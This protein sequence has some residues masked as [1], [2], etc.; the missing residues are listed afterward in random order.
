MDKAQA[1]LKD[2]YGVVVGQIAGVDVVA[3]SGGL[4][5]ATAYN[6]VYTSADKKLTLTPVTAG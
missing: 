4:Q 6:L 2:D 5:N 1:Q 3:P